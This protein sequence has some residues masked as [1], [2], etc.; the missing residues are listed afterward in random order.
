MRLLLQL[1]F[2][3]LVTFCLSTSIA[4]AKLNYVT[5]EGHGTGVTP[6]EAVQSALV[7]ALGKVNGMQMASR[8]RTAMSSVKVTAEVQGKQGVA[9]LNSEEFQ[10][11]IQT[12]TKGLIKSYEVVSIKPDE[13]TAGL[14]AVDLKATVIKYAKS[15]QANRN[16]IAVLPFRVD[17]AN[18]VTQTTF[19]KNL[20]QG[21]V[22]YLTQTRRF[23]VL[24]RDFQDESNGE[25]NSLKSADVPMEE[26]ARLG[27]R[28]GAD[29]IVVG[30]INKAVSK[31][32]NK[33][34][35]STGKKFPMSR[36]GAA[37]SYRVM[38]VATGQI[39]FSQLYDGIGT[40]QGYAPDMSR[41]AKKYADVL[42][43]QLVEGIFP[44]LVVSVSGKSMY[45]GQGG[46]TIKKGQKFTLIQ[47]GKKMMDPYTKESLGREEI[48]VGIVQVTDVQAKSSRANIL[49][50]S[51]DINALF[52]PN[53]FIVRLIK[54]SGGQKRA[55]KKAKKVEK[56][57]EKSMVE[58]EKESSDDW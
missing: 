34:M 6:K 35:K 4:F 23:A 36:Y 25:L 48:P 58:M 51:V 49:K 32:W 50:C 1:L 39:M 22:G 37:L 56:V 54:G 55:A 46:E 12:A 11:E 18:D 17:N 26:M 10:Q 57:I 3:P 43:K 24:D 8:E 42:G 16:R 27:N 29:F 21:L 14:L 7:D 9:E 38:D 30:Q 13:Y 45:I 33:E 28:L 31:Q 53:A 20:C 5:V 41:I 44:L 47:Y 2:I 15:K 40:H 52:A 19:A